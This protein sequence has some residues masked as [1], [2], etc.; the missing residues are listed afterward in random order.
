MLS[1]LKRISSGNFI[2]VL[3]TISLAHPIFADEKIVAFSVTS[4]TEPGQVHWTEGFLAERWACFK[5]KMFPTMKSLMEGIEKSHYLE[6]FKIA[7]GLVPGRSR[8]APFNDGDF[9]KWMQSAIYL[10]AQSPDLELEKDIDSIIEIIGKA[11]REDGYLHTPVI[12]KSSQGDPEAV[13]FNNRHNFELYNMGHLFTT[14]ALHYRLTGKR[15]LLDVAIKAADFLDR[16]FQEAPP[17]AARSSVC[18]SHYMGMIDLWRVTKDRKYL[19]LVE[20]FFKFRSLISDGGD[21]NQDRIPFKDQ[22]EAVGHAVRANYLYAG[23]ADLYI[24]TG[25][26]EY[27]QPLLPIWKNVISKK[28][29]I[30]G[31]CG[32]LYD[33]ASPDGSKKQRSITRTHQ[34]YG[35]NYQLPNTTAHNETCANIGNVLWNWRMFLATGEAQFIDILELALFNSVLSGV[36]LDGNK[37]FYTNPLRVTEPLPTPLRWSRSRVPYV[38]AFCCPPNVL[39]TIGESSLYAYAQK[40]NTVWV[41]LYGGSKFSGKIGGQKIQILQKTK[42]PWDGKVNLTINHD[43]PDSIDF[44]LKLRIPGW[45][46]NPQIQISSKNPIQTIGT[47]QR[48]GSYVGISGGWHNGDT[49][50]LELPMPAVIVESHPLVEENRNHVALKRGPIV[51]CLESSDLPKGTKIH[52]VKISPEDRWVPKWEENLLEGV[53]TL[54]GS[55]QIEFQDQWQNQL[56]RPYKPKDFKSVPVRLIPYALWGNRGQSEMTVWIPIGN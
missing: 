27:W 54:N 16:T 5:Q 21:D 12:I 39:R 53:I 4:S 20:K 44:T 30:T 35:R 26:S 24:E 10:L 43:A 18:P 55:L 15:Q 37:F 33:G 56:Y 45:S 22:R 25:K 42:Y 49:I 52:D 11:Q 34:A 1:N 40:K 41:N 46:S 23:A 36:D 50:L 8:G 48:P 32:A 31:A 47:N 13:P 28:M 19:R 17:E 6:N 14:A 29:Y 2:I 38:S 9:Y 51:Y 7:A 3:L